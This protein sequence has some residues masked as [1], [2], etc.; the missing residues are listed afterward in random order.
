VDLFLAYSYSYAYVEEDLVSPTCWDASAL[1]LAFEP[2]LFHLCLKN[3]LLVEVVVHLV[4][5]SV[6]LHGLETW[7]H[8]VAG[9]LH[10]EA[11][12]GQEGLA[13]RREIVSS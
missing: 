9:G 11:L 12:L 5:D 6:V 1:F 7:D 10:L 3:V 8:V 13:G 4:E 2:V